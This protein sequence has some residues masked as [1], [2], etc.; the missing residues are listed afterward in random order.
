MKI[1]H[2][3]I[4]GLFKSYL[5]DRLPVSRAKCPLPDDI[6]ACIRGESTKK[7]RNQIIDHVLHCAYCH[8]EFEFALGI[9]R[10]EEKFIKDLGSIVQEKKKSRKKEYLQF[11][12][13]RPSWL[14][15]LI[16]ITVVVMLTLLVK[17]M[18][19]ER[20]YRGSETLSITLITPNKKATLRYQLKF[21]WEDIQNSDYYILEVFDESLYPIWKSDKITV[22]YT[23]L[24]QEITNRFLIHKTY[25]WMI[26]AFLTDGK[27]IESKLQD[28]R[29]SD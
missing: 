27:T 8:E 14:H 25:Y 29:I 9:I 21:E 4:K 19:E 11:F 2:K 1:N 16:L 22:N 15:S 28:F 18:T 6:T 5:E 10:G 12:P 20:K 7:R 3:D 26:T 23:L 13:F 24:S 17:D